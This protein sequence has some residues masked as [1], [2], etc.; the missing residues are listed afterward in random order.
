[1][2]SPLEIYQ[3][4][5]VYIFFFCFTLDTQTHLTLKKASFKAFDP[6]WQVTCVCIMQVASWHLPSTIQLEEEVITQ[7]FMSITSTVGGLS[8]LP[9]P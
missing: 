7:N 6:L 2:K 9:K 4:A 5:P 3:L 1:M 8:V